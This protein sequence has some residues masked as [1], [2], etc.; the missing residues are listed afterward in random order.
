M[1]AAVAFCLLILTWS[2]AGLMFSPDPA[3]GPALSPEQVE[4]QMAMRGYY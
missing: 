1:T 4:Q 3:A 2:A